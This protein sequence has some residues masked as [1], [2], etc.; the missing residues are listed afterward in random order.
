M[1]E[2]QQEHE[3]FRE[4]RSQY[5][6]IP[7]PPA[8]DLHIELGVKQAKKQRKLFHARLWSAAACTLLVITFVTTVRI[9]SSFA[10]WVTQ[11]PGLDAIVKMIN[12]D[13]GLS[14]ALENDFM[15][16]IG[17]SDEHD[18][19]KVTVDGII[20]DEVRMNVFYS[21]TFPE[22]RINANFPNWPNI[23]FEGDPNN[24]PVMFN[25]GEYKIDKENRKQFHSIL[26]LEYSK[27][28][29]PFPNQVVF[30]LPFKDRGTEW[31]I[32]FTIDSSK[33]LGLK[34]TFPIH[35]AISIDDQKFTIEEAT[36][37]PTRLK[38]DISCDPN[39]TK[40]IFD[41]RDLRIVNENGEALKNTGS[42][43]Y[44]DQKT[45]LFESN[46]FTMPKQLFIEG[47]LTAALDRNQLDLVIDP[48]KKEIIKRPDDR[49]RL[50]KFVPNGDKIDVELALSNINAKQTNVFHVTSGGFVETTGQKTEIGSKSAYSEGSHSNEK[51]INEFQIPNR[52][53]NG[54]L[55]FR[56][57]YYPKFIEQPFR[58]QIK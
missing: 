5:N 50:Q 12:G 36:M 2:T 11:I 9:S 7:M 15:Q 28:P 46:Y 34:H 41:L 32:P 16:P 21:V 20:V 19:V 56:I 10:A 42:I 4:I 17:L 6:Q 13:R 37:Y 31:T 53:Y 51:I 27:S 8:L 44:G 25:F 40:Q 1:C 14:L 3:V 24:Q 48:I 52:D 54:P 22:E 43:G 23:A 33:F 55:T 58:V 45:Y 47:S 35:Q 26:Q 39:N 49:I 18:G 30:H 29:V 57:E 38:L